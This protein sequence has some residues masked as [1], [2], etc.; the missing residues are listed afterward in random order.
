MYDLQNPNRSR[1]PIQTQLDRSQD[2]TNYS[3][4][5]AQYA[6]GPV[7]A[8]HAQ[9]RQ[10]L[11]Y[12]PWSDNRSDNRADLAKSQQFT[13]TPNRQ[14]DSVAQY[15]RPDRSADVYAERA[16]FGNDETTIDQFR[17]D[18]SAISYP[19]NVSALG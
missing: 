6:P 9:E 16:H 15:K 3:A 13:T 7:A 4:H 1:S 17:G 11:S 5:T 19:Q 2:I 14:P 10:Q 8:G 12:S 18:S